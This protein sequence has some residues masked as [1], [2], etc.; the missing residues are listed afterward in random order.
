MILVG[1]TV[2]FRC[3]IDKIK[4]FNLLSDLCMIPLKGIKWS[5]TYNYEVSFSDINM[6]KQ[7]KIKEVLQHK[8][9]MN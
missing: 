6:G 5:L 4:T 7:E 2:I 8:L 1:C 9:H 3:R